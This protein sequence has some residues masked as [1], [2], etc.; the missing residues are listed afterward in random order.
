MDKKLSLIGKKVCAFNLIKLGI[1]KRVI[2][3]ATGF[4]IKTI[5]KIAKSPNSNFL[6]KKKKLMI[7]DEMDRFLRIFFQR[8]S[9]YMGG[10]LRKATQ[11]LN[12]EF[13]ISIK[14]VQPVRDWLKKNKF[15]R[16]NKI[17]IDPYPKRI[18]LK[19]LAFAR[20]LVKDLSISKKI[21]FTDEKTFQLRT[22]HHKNDKMWAKK[23]GKNPIQ[24]G[25]LFNN[26]Y[27]KISAGISLFGKTELI[28]L[29]TKFNGKVYAEQ[30]LPVFKDEISKHNLK[31]F[32]QDNST[33]HYEKIYCI[34][35]LEEFENILNWPPR[36]PDLNPIE[37]LWSYLSYKLRFRKCE[38]IRQLKMAIKEEYDQIPESITRNLCNSFHSRLKK[39]I[40]LK[41]QM[42]S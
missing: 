21:L 9:S 42:I 1:S 30:V 17:I 18:I 6:R 12:E 25:I 5:Q 36:S 34:P 41:G 13:G 24:H 39:C 29:P 3:K 38:N 2:K 15:I 19:R 4:C 28:F 31:Y 14:S 11:R 23:G 7:T 37:N 8:Y 32:M 22:K 35:K 20:K 26:D 27:V 33:I 10:S 16:K 40:E